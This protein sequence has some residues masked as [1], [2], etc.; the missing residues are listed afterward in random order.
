MTRPPATLF[1]TCGLPGSGKTTLARRLERDHSALRLT[2]DEWLCDLHPELSEAERDTLRD[3]VER[4]Q[5]ST[6]LGVLALG[7]NV[8]LDW[9][10]WAR[11]ER[12]RYRSQAQAIGARVVL[13]PLEPTRQKLLDRLRP[14]N[15]APG[16]GVFRVTEDEFERAWHFFQRERPTPEELALF[17]PMP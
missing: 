9:G 11:E 17:D 8:V 14:R 10:L 4:I 13:C 6:A 12:D 7:A 15:A 16:P 3:R 5:W 2:A 1:L